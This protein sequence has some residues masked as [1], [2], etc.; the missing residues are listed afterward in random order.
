MVLHGQMPIVPISYHLSVSYHQIR[1]VAVARQL[2]LLRKQQ[3][4][5]LPL[6]R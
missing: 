5:Q 2:G 3:L 6:L 4:Y 1:Q